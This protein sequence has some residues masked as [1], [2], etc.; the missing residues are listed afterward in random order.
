MKLTSTSA[1]GVPFKYTVPET[2]AVAG[3]VPDLPQPT[4]S[5]IA[6]IPQRCVTRRMKDSP[7][8]NPQLFARYGSRCRD[9]AAYIA[10]ADI[11]LQYYPDMTRMEVAFLAEKEKVVHLDDLVMRRSLMAYLG[12]LTRPLIH[13]LAGVLSGILGWND[14]QKQEEIRKTIEMLKDKHGVRI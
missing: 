2:A 13:E 9:I 8:C 3:P 1:A 10:D 14:E 4:N 11:P 12:H 6:A 7:E 5:V